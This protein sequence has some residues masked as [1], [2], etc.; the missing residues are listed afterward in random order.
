MKNQRTDLN[1]NLKMAQNVNILNT[2]NTK[3]FKSPKSI[4]EKQPQAS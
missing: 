2:V 4:K 1:P 3:H